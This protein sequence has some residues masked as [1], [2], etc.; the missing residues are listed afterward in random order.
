MADGLPPGLPPGGERVADEV[1]AGVPQGQKAS[2][3]SCIF[4]T[5]NFA[6]FVYLER[7]ELSKVM[8]RWERFGTRTGQLEQ[9]YIGQSIESPTG[10]CHCVCM[11]M[12]DKNQTT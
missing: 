12:Q 10:D 6:L 9:L 4:K 8:E 7:S 5:N 11:L 3:V 2:F 1:P